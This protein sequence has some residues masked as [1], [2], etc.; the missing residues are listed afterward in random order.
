MLRIVALT[1]VASFSAAGAGPADRKL[2]DPRS[3][4]SAVN[5]RARAIPIDDLF[6]PRVVQSGAWSPN[7]KEVVFVTNLTGRFNLWKVSAAGGFPVQLAQSDDEQSK[8]AWSPDGKWIVFEQDRGGNEKHDLY[9]IPANGGEIMNLTSTADVDETGARWSPDGKSL[10]FG[11]KAKESPVYDLAVIDL[12]TRKVRRLTQEKDARYN[13]ESAG[14]TPDGKT[15]FANRGEVSVTDGRV[16]RI[17]LSTGTAEEL[18]SHK[19]EIVYAATSVFPDGKTLV[20]HSTEKGGYQNIGLL[21]VASKKISW[22]TDTQWEAVAGDAA[23]D[24]RTFTYSINED[25]R[26]DTW[27]V[28]RAT[29]RARKL[30]MPKGRNSSDAR[31]TAYSPGSD[32]VLLWHR[33]S[34]EA[35][36]I[37]VYDL[38]RDTARQLT[39]SAIASLDPAALPQTQIVHYPSFDGRL[40]SAL[41]WVPFNLQRDAKSPGLVLPHGG[42]TSQIADWWQPDVA[43][44]VSR[45]YVCIAPNVRGSTGYGM[46]FQRANYQDLGGGDLQDEV[47][48]AKFLEA[49]GFVDAKRIG[50]YGGSYGGFMT[51]MALGKTPEL[52]AAGVALYGI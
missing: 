9:A 36:D 45:G 14:F 18:T 29:H 34:R 2:A 44:L 41:L 6:F 11:I 24:G 48:A 47:A 42:P 26:T 35:R 13:W 43:A 22:V 46:E 15:I 5:P 12:A 52:W 37:W 30:A 25:G 20:L 1:L 39:F 31:P 38:R 23:P 40:I 33:S 17:H 28:D 19:S 3:I 10:V 4:V 16:F 7:G 51:L 32:R 8:P 49:T 27:L 21:D 50:M